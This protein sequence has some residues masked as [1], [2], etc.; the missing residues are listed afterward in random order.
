MPKKVKK[1]C[2]DCG[3]EFET[4]S[5]KAK[6]CPECRRIKS[7]I[8]FSMKK[9]RAKLWLLLDHNPS[10]AIRIVNDMICEDGINFTTQVL[11]EE[12]LQA[13]S[14]ERYMK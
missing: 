1:I 14:K 9:I 8:F 4:Y 13:I 2:V 5:K 11:G 3:I 10:R 7:A 6:R 12:L